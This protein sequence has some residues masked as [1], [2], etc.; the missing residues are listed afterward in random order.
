M[1]FSASQFS[2]T[3]ASE[4]DLVLASYPNQ[5]YLT[6][7]AT[8]SEVEGDFAID[9]SFECGTFWQGSV[10]YLVLMVGVALVIVVIFVC[11]LCGLM[12]KKRKAQTHVA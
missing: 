7:K 5:V 6:V 12:Y 10:L 4:G 1:R 3:Q 8:S 2:E 9:Y 11:Y